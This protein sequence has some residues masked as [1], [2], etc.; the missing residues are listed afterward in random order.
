MRPSVTGVLAAC[1]LSCALIGCKS[2]S[3]VAE[4]DENCIPAQGPNTVGSAAVNTNCP[5]T[6]EHADQAILADYQGSKIA[7]CCKGCLGRF[8]R[9][10]DAEKSKILAT[11]KT[12]PAK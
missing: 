2:S 12:Y 10:S 5:F 8:N 1:F 11:A 6:G 3:E 4:G 9:M 7:F